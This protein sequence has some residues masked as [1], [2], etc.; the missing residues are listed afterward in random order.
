MNLDRGVGHING[1]V[2]RKGSLRGLVDF[3]LDI[4][5]SICFELASAS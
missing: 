3:G 2:G 5:I 4:K 1:G